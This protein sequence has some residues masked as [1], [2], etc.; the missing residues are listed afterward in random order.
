[1]GLEKYFECIN[2]MIGGIFKLWNNFSIEA[3]LKIFKRNMKLDLDFG[4]YCLREERMLFS[5]YKS[6]FH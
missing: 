4:I 5:F 3:G 1:M 6:G 2:N